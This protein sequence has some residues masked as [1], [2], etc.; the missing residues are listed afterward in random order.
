MLRCPPQA[1]SQPPQIVVTGVG[2]VS[3]LGM[4]WKD[5]EQAFRDQRTGFGPISRFDVRER[6]A[7]TAALVDLPDDRLFHTLSARAEAR[8]D[9]GTRML[10]LAIREAMTQAALPSSDPVQAMI[11]GTSAAA[12]QHGESY[13]R[14]LLTSPRR[15]RGQ[16]TR[17]EHYQPQTQ[18]RTLADELGWPGQVMLISNACASGANAVGT[19]LELLR[20]GRAQCVITGGYDAITELVFAGF[21]ALRALAPSGLPRPFDAERDGLALG[22][23]AGV[24]ILE[25]SAHAHARGATPIALLG[26]YHTATDLHHLTQPDPAGAAAVRTMT[27]ACEMAGLTPK[28]VDYINSHGTGTP[29]NDAAESAAIATWAGDAL[30]RVPVSSTKSAMG[31]LLGGAGAVEAGICVMS[32]AGQWVPGSLNIRTPDPAA[33]FDL[34][35]NFRPARVR[36]ALTNSFGFGGTNASLV[37]RSV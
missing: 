12:M 15:I 13:S 7:H 37:F 9:H 22:E 30:S 8:V 11:I 29:F 28:E 5:H 21:D 36:S 23:G 3:A 14:T 6:T 16:T 19:G 17:V 27:R 1:D 31:H 32:L 24:L 4:G 20:S 18:M 35:R 34:V 26:G 33:R 10:L 2:L 25:T